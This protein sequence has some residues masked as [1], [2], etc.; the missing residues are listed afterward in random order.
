MRRTA[1]ALV[2]IVLLVGAMPASA[3][4]WCN[5]PAKNGRVGNG[6][7]THDWILDRAIKQAGAGGSWVARSTALL[8][9]DDPD[10]SKTLA[11]YHWY[12]EVGGCRGAPH[13]VGELY[14][15]AVI[16]YRAGDRASASRYLGVLSHYYADITQ[17][18]HTTAAA[19][20]YG[21]LHRQYEYAVDDFQNT[22]TKSYFW[23]TPRAVVPVTDIRSKTVDAAL[24][25]RSL[26]PSLLA[27]YRVSHSVTSGTPKR[28]TRLVM[29]RAV[30]D[31]ADIIASIPT[32][33]GEA[34]APAKVEL[35]LS[36]VNPRQY[37]RVGAFVTVTGADGRPMNAVGVRLV[38]SLPTGTGTWL[39]FTEA[40]GS[41]TRW[42]D[43]G[44]APVGQ[45]STVTAYVTV[46]GVTT[47]ATTGFMTVR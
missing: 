35:S 3:L 38:W 5:G 42:I 32:G 41:A 16:A 2:L 20:A 1:I 37:Q 39:T 25:A 27:S 44:A 14:H 11:A 19:A 13:M 24:Y 4:A 40:N 7:G 47:T 17:P 36:R 23:V 6:Y 21:T 33:S 46:N 10:S 22:P 29:S 8:A 45:T 12:R 43:I 28:V 31:L 15:K 18:F 9:T 26:F 30:N 34:T